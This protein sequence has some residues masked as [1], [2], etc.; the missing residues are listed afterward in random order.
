MIIGRQVEVM[1][2]SSLKIAFRFSLSS[3]HDLYLH[4][5]LSSSLIA[6]E[7]TFFE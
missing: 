2:E 6:L 4:L 3:E 5:R 7:I 1:N